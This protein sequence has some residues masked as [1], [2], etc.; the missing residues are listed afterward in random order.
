MDV[1]T[2]P[3][4]TRACKKFGLN[5]TALQTS[6]LLR[7]VRY[8]SGCCRSF[9][10]SCHVRAAFRAGRHDSLVLQIFLDAH[11]I[12]FVKYSAIRSVHR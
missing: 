6:G 5:S 8:G 4:S 3:C 11:F 1:H 12:L 2:R 10:G 7:Y 9:V